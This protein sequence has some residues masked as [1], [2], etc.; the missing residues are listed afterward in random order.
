MFL[1]K[2]ML[3]Q[4]IG[5]SLIL[6]LLIGCVSG[7]GHTVNGENLTNAEESISETEEE[8]ADTQESSPISSAQAL[9]EKK[10][11]QFKRANADI[12]V[13]KEGD[14]KNILIIGQ[15]RRASQKDKM[16]SDSMMIFS[17]N[18]VTNEIN[19]ISL[20]RDMY[21][22]C[23]DGKEG[24]INLTYLN[25][26]PELLEQTIE[27]N[28][29]IYIDNYVETDFWRFMDLFTCLGD[30]ELE[31]SV[32][33]AEAVNS[34]FGAAHMEYF[35]EQLTQPSC[36]LT[37]GI[38]YL[39]PEQLLDYCRV[40]QNIGGDWA[41]TERQRKAI[42]ATY[43]KL[44]NMSYAGLIRLIKENAKLFCTDMDVEDM[45]GYYYWLK[46][47]DINQINSYRLPLEG[48][49]TQEIREGSL[50]VLIPQIEPNKSAIQQYVYG[51]S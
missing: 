20:M 19:L 15:D 51:D 21:I 33:E 32:G 10:L 5:L 46:K 45:L 38:N 29:G 41:R 3:F 22:P 6:I 11:K 16:R 25:G 44:N 42:I 23:A 48:T 18:T 35:D 1:R 36:F 7:C 40:R 30:I 17:I 31:L 39:N 24:M 8:S 26:G 34:A 47:N 12:S 14:V 43:N 49:Y 37:G 28:F 4:I 13:I 9:K 27:M 2:G 50:S